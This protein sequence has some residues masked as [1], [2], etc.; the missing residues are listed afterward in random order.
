ML[1]GSRSKPNSGMRR[2][3]RTCN[4]NKD[5]SVLRRPYFHT[6]IPTNRNHTIRPGLKLIFS[7]R[8]KR[9][10]RQSSKS[11]K[12]IL[13]NYCC[14]SHSQNK[15]REKLL[16]SCNLPWLYGVKSCLWQHI[17]SNLKLLS[18]KDLHS[19]FHIW[20][21]YVNHRLHTHLHIWRGHA[22]LKGR[23]ELHS[24]ICVLYSCIVVE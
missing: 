14:L 16:I 3:T 9:K 5:S 7:I 1:K 21:W 11:I 20:S 24:L 18:H 2:S 22:G 4:T 8:I 19:P 15:F 23:C 6:I 13:Q 17:W 10:N 12:I